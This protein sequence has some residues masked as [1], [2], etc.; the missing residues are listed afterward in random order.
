MSKR[1]A[2]VF[3]VHE[4]PR[5]VLSAPRKPFLDVIQRGANV[6][7]LFQSQVGVSVGELLSGNRELGL[8]VQRVVSEGFRSQGLDG[9]SVN[10]DGVRAWILSPDEEDLQAAHAFEGHLRCI[11]GSW[12]VKVPKAK[13]YKLKTSDTIYVAPF[14]S[15]W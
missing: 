2:L 9:L 8:F 5:A 6:I 11:A 3:T 13:P 7:S 12:F 10:M 1:G 14:G 4:N 15:S